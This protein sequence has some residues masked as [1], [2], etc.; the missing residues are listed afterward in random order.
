MGVE[1]SL[2]AAPRVFFCPLAGNDR[3]ECQGTCR[4]RPHQ[5][6]RNRL[7]H[8]ERPTPAPSIRECV[9]HMQPNFRKAF[10]RHR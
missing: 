4:L 5:G 9:R 8:T 2:E 7:P 6:R 10:P 3:D 1:M